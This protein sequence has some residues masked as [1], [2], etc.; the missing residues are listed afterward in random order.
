MYI[1]L[2]T[3]QD[4]FVLTKINHCARV[5]GWVTIFYKAPK[6]DFSAFIQTIIAC[7]VSYGFNFEKT[8]GVEIVG[9]MVSG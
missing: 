5:N 7:G 3:A 9:K 8:F 6:E 1:F 2:G 4:L